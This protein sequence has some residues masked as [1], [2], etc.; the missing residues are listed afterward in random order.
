MV[1][2]VNYHISIGH[3]ILFVDG[4]PDFPDIRKATLPLFTKLATL[5]ESTL[6]KYSRP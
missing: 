6:K 3:G 5:P 1:L 2:K 4:V